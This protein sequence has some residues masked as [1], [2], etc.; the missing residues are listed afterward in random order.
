[1]KPTQSTQ[2]VADLTDNRIECLIDA[3]RLG[4]RVQV[5]AREISADFAGKPLLVV[6]VL[7]GAFVFMA[8]L[9]RGLTI[10]VRCGFVMVS[11]YGENTVSSGQVEL[12]LDLTQPVEGQHV[13]L[14]DDIVDTGI[15]VASLVERVIRRGPASVRICALLDKPTRRRVPVKVDYLG[16][17]VPDRFVVGYGIDWAG[18]YRELPYVGYLSA[19]RGPTQVQEEGRARTDGGD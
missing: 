7:Q 19:T 10:P 5:L 13:L 15:S 11:S 1:M 18:R 4:E 16:F 17:E 3:S 8:D 2:T 12:R 9:V 14:V 6:G